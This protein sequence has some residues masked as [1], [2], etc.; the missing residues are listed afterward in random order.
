MVRSTLADAAA[1]QVESAG[2]AAVLAFGAAALLFPAGTTVCAMIAV[3]GT[4]GR[5]DGRPADCGTAAALSVPMIETAS[6]RAKAP[7]ARRRRRNLLP[8]LGF[9]LPIT[10]AAVLTECHHL[11]SKGMFLMRHTPRVPS[12]R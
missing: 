1:G 11:V 3:A 6:P 5:W 9:D 8:V 10:L 4:A 12:R 7:R 2:A